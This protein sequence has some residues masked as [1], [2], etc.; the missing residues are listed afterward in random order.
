[1][2]PKRF[3]SAL[4]GALLLVISLG[5]LGW[6]ARAYEQHAADSTPS[7]TPLALATPVATP[8]PRLAALQLSAKAAVLIDADTGRVLYANDADAPRAPASTAK[9]VTAL[10]VL[11]HARPEEIVTI[12]PSDVVDASQSSMGLQIGDSVTVHDLLVGMLLPSGN[13]AARVLARVAGE[14]LPGTQ[15]PLDRFIAEMNAV[16]AGLGMDGSHFSDPAGDDAAGQVVTA[17]GLAL[18]AR[19]LL[20]E[21]ALLSIVAMP[22]AEVRVGGPHA[23]TLQLTNTNELLATEGVFGVKTGTTPLA[24]QCLVVAYRTGSQ[25]QIAVV[26]GSEDR[27]ADAR[28]LLNLPP[29][30]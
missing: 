24:G 16:A 26:L 17:R 7:P 19:R 3:R 8:D 23:R 6:T 20:Q 29:G 21:P 30:G 28:A 4:L 9:L 5:A 14:R 13:D 2:P 1:M 18:A 22:K 15:P 11:R 25:T 12:G 10:T 27:Y